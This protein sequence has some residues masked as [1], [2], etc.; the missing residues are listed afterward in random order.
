MAW[1]SRHKPLP[2]QI[3]ELRR[4]FGDVEIIQISRTF[5]DAGDV[6]EDVKASGAEY[7]V[8]VLP[9]SMIARLVQYPGV[10]WLWAQMR[11][12]HECLGPGRCAEFN[13]DSDAWLPLHG[14]EKGRHMRFETFK[15]IQRVVLVLE[16]FQG[17]C[18]GA[19]G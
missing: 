18:D 4:I 14:S 12:L 2:A 3:R 13:P 17:G 1:V 7:A 5:R 6:Y 16:D 19:E 15:K 11:A 9:L 8:V 10:D